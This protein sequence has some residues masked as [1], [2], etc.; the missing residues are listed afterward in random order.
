MRITKIYA[1]KRTR[2]NASFLQTYFAF[3]YCIRHCASMIPDN[4]TK[5]L[6]SYVYVSVNA[7][8]HRRG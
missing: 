6:K 4:Q 8:D 5:L 3:M 7:A 2:I 1:R